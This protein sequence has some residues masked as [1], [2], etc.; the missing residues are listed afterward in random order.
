MGKESDLW[1][2]F[3]SHVAGKGFFERIENG[4]GSG[5][6]DVDYTFRCSIRR[7]QRTGKVELKVIDHLPRFRK[8]DCIFVSHF[9]K[10]QRVWHTRYA[11][12]GGC[13]FVLLYIRDIKS[14]WLFTGKEACKWMG[15]PIEQ[16]DLEKMNT[17]FKSTGEFP[18]AQL[19]RVL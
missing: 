2:D 13:S 10:A 3:R 14:Y 8:D 7:E 19:L 6:P 15:K 18:I 17:I 12:Y 9:R 4:V 11:M 16:G 5:N 1:A